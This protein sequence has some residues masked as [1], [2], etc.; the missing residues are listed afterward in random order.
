[1]DWLLV[2]SY[3]IHSAYFILIYIIDFVEILKLAV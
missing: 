3:L 2:L 1:M